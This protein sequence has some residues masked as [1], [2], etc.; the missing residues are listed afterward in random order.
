MSCDTTFIGL[1]GFEP[2]TICPR[3]LCQPGFNHAAVAPFRA[4]CASQP[5][6][7]IWV[8]WTC[9]GTLSKLRVTPRF[10]A[11]NWTQKQLRA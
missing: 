9:L 8:V 10:P 4:F 2:A 11:P 6:H 1:T 5:C 7:T 3:E